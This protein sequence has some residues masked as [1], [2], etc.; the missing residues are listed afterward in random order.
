MSFRHLHA[1]RTAIVWAFPLAA[2]ILTAGCERVSYYSISGASSSGGSATG[3][4][5]GGGGGSTKRGDVLAAAGTCGAA[6]YRDF[7]S[8]A[9]ELDTAAQSAAATPSEENENAV[10]AAWSKAIDLWQQ[11]EVIRV[12]PAAPAS[13]PGGQGLR[14]FVYSWPLV[15]RC[16]VEQTLVAKTYE[17][18]TF[19]KTALINVRGLAAAEY[20]LFYEGT[21]NACSANATINT[22]GTWAALTPAE[23]SNRKAAYAVVVAKDVTE[24]AAA[25]AQ[26][27][28]P[29]GGNYAGA[30]ANPGSGGSSFSS[31][32]LALNALSDG[33]FYIERE[34]KDL[35]LGRPLG[36]VDCASA[37]CPEAVESL[38]AKRSRTHV[39]NNLQGFRRIFEGCDE[40][41]Q[42]GFD[43]L[44]VSVGAGD[45]AGRMTSDLAAA[46]AAA[47][48]LG[49]DDLGLALQTERPA[50]EALHA[51]IKKITDAMKTEFVTVLDLDLPKIVEGD[52]D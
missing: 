19:M 44:L 30:L 34:V 43:D 31:E 33:L 18:P 49:T 45:L 15:S 24:K 11:A 7:H 41:E 14:D 10:R 46:I 42:V 48:A 13:V 26:A 5:T 12:G 4:S 23:L 35:K 2:C 28:S 47:D 39:R 22:M 32:Q 21:D 1:A 25:L 38:Y 51:A 27:W 20:L 37:S 52:N 16:L 9:K 6:L 40:A 17:S 8:A 29:D 50:V 3:T 36:L